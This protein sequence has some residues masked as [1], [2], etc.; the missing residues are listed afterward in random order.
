MKLLMEFGSGKNSCWL[1]SK[2]IEAPEGVWID[3]DGELV[4]YHLQEGQ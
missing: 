3:E 4:F 2:G 1:C